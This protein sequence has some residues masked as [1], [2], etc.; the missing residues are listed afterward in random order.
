MFCNYL[1]KYNFRIGER[2][3]DGLVA[4]LVSDFTPTTA[5]FHTKQIGLAESYCATTARVLHTPVQVT[6]SGYSKL[7]HSEHAHAGKHSVGC[8]TRIPGWVPD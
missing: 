6:Q 5:P 1:Q 8:D 2:L 4:E 3:T 7:A